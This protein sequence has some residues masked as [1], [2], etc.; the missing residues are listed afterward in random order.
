MEFYVKLLLGISAFCGIGTIT[1]WVGV[2]ALLYKLGAERRKINSE[3]N[4]SDAEAG[5]ADADTMK[6]R[7]DTVVSLLGELE[8][9][10]ERVN[11]L[12][13][14]ERLQ[15][16]EISNIKAVFRQ[17]ETV[18]RE[19][20]NYAHI[21]YWEASSDGAR[22]AFNEAWFELTGLTFEESVGTGWQKCVHDEDLNKVRIHLAQ[23]WR[24]A[25]VRPLRFRVINQL[26]SETIEVESMIYVV[27]NLDGTVNKI[28]GR[29]VRL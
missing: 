13:E 29:K 23:A 3:A 25:T 17:I 8:S 10:Q 16:V 9:I 22:T 28:I 26:T 6:T 24:G 4:K 15:T 7:A 19:I 2:F 14:K 20:L 1:G 12:F 5:K 21:G 11:S 27:Y 18:L